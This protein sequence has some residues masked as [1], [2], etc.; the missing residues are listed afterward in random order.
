MINLKYFF[1]RILLNFCC[2]K[3]YISGFDIY[4][5]FSIIVVNLILKDEINFNLY[6]QLGNGRSPQC[7][8][9]NQV[10]VQKMIRT[11]FQHIKLKI[12]I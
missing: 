12:S 1:T 8:N 10:F 4:N 3:I 5:V 6:T 2:K 9:E 11:A 7:S